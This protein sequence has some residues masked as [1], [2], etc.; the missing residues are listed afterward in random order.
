MSFPVGR[1]SAD[2]AGQFVR[3]FCPIEAANDLAGIDPKVLVESGKALVLLDADNTLLPWRSEDIPDSSIDWIERAKAAGLKICLVSNTRNRPRLDGL[4]ERLG[5]IVAEGKFKP[6]RSMFQWALSH[7]GLKSEQAVMIGD[8]IFTDVFGANRSGVEA[9]LVRPMGTREFIGT[10][11]NRF[12]EKILMRRLVHTM[13]AEDDDLPIVAPRGFFQRRIVRQ[14][15]KFCIVGGTSFA[16]D[17]SIR[18]TLQFATKVQ[19]E[20]VSET[21]GRWM[22]SNL[23]VGFYAKTPHDA[24]F[25]V[26]A[27]VAGSVAIVNSFIWNRMWT[28]KI[29]GA[30]ERGEQFRRFVFLSVS[31]VLLNTLISGGINSALTHMDDKVAARIATLIATFFVA[32]WNFFGQRLY[33]FRPKGS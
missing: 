10:K 28:F 14:F 3:R 22:M 19:G 26:A 33:A 11:F 13:Q 31:G 16:I 15:A 25:P 24:F 7:F 17:Y 27:L 4:S 12:L 6:S 23:P 30:E 1:Y 5:I 20:L 18:M 8:Q 32:F 2:Q 21:A 9:I 29:R